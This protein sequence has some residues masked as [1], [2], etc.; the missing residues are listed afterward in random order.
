MKGSELRRKYIEFFKSRGHAEIKMPRNYV[1]NDAYP[2]LSQEEIETRILNARSQLPSIAAAI[3]EGRELTARHVWLFETL[4]TVP[5]NP[6]WCKFKLRADDF[7]TTDKCVGCGKCVKLCPLNNITLK[8]GKPVWSD[9]LP[10]ISKKVRCT[11]SPT[12]SMSPV[13]IHF[14][15]SVSLLPAGC[16]AP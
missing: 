3:R 8:D 14:W 5:F 6:V 15:Q 2:M 16:F 4:I 7:F 11:G 9:Q 13:L 12:S 1:A 10:S